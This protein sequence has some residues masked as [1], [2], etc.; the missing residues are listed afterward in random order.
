M[1]IKGV[2]DTDKLRFQN[3][4]CFINNAKSI[5]YWFG[6]FRSTVILKRNKYL[7]K[8]INKY[9]VSKTRIKKYF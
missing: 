8:Y 6:L 7:I 5:K 2:K 1:L 3:V 9:N 4:C